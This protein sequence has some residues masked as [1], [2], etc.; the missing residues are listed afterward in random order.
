MNYIQR[1]SLILI[2][3]ILLP[4]LYSMDQSDSFFKADTDEL[5]KEKTDY[6]NKLA[7]PNGLS[8]VGFIAD[9]EDVLSI[10][11][12]DAAILKQMNI[13]HKQ[14]GD[15]ID[16]IIRKAQRIFQEN[17]DSNG[18]AIIE[19][20]IRVPRYLTTMGYQD[21]L[22]GKGWLET[23]G[24]GSSFIVLENL[25]NPKLKL[26][27]VTELH[28]HLIRDH[29]F[30]QGSTPYRIDP[31]LAIETLQILPKVDYSVQE[32]TSLDWE[33]DLV[34]SYISPVNLQK[35]EQNATKTFPIANG[36]AIGYLCS[37]GNLEFP[38]SQNKSD[39][40]IEFLHVIVFEDLPKGTKGKIELD[41]ANLETTYLIAKYSTFQKKLNREVI[42]GND[43]RW[44]PE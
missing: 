14:I 25:N 30:F 32:R 31:L 28:G 29:H 9:N 2:S 1:I 27:G 39:K 43:D 42:L 41:G 35:L 4:S 17:D 11:K 23:C 12:A 24:K 13:T 20:I 26:T 44:Y 19:G 22:F 18:C 10:A 21:C 36:K 7:R 16:S 40:N 15:R 33:N 37:F 3:V 6:L 5:S 34:S 38:F 8:Q